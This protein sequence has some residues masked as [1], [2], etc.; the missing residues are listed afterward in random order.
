MVKDQWLLIKGGGALILAKVNVK[1]KVNMFL[2]FR[3]T[4]LVNSF[5]F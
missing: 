1:L 5:L 2:T 4:K 3:L